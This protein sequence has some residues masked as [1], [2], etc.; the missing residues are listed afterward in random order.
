MLPAPF[1]CNLRSSHEQPFLLLRLHHVPARLHDGPESGP[2]VDEDL[3][4]RVQP[5]AAHVLALRCR[6][7]RR[8]PI[9]VEF[10]EGARRTH[11]EVTDPERCDV[12][13]EMGSLRRLDRDALNLIFNDTPRA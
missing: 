13:E 4:F 8:K 5:Y 1:L 11:R 3:E 9:V 10:G 6:R 12:L 2:A 7:L